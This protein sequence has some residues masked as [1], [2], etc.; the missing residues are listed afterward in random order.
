[1]NLFGHIFPAVFG[2]PATRIVLNDTSPWC[3]WGQVVHCAAIRLY[4][5]SN[6][7][8]AASIAFRFCASLTCGFQMS[9]VLVVFGQ[10]SGGRE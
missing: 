5:T 9:V 2:V 10:R 4:S 1:V 6:V 3:P 7:F 8:A